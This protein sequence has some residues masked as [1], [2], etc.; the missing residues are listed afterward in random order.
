[1]KPNPIAILCSDLHLSIKPPAC[2]ADTNWLD[3]QGYYLEQLKKLAGHH[4][5]I[6]AGDI[7]D[8]WN[9][10]AELIHFALDNL[11]NDMICIPGQHDLPNHAI[12]EMHRS[13]YG[14]L[15]RAKKIIDLSEE[16]T[17]EEP[18][19]VIYGAGWGQKIPVCK[20]THLKDT[21]NLLVM[22]DFIWIND[23]TKYPGA[24]EDSDIKAHKDKFKQFDAVAIGDNHRGWLRPA[25]GF[26]P[27]TDVINCGTFLRRK[28]DELA[29]CPGVGVLYADGTIE[30]R[31]LDTSIDKFHA[32]AKQREEVAV[33]LEEFIE[34][35]EG[36]GEHG[37]NF[38]E[39]VELHLRTEKIDKRTKEIVLGAL[40]DNKA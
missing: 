16:A 17:H 37:L 18:G 19:L 28:S 31:F 10:N 22:H 12:S 29:Y 27:K 1:M 2:R 33:D 11:P 23:A 6:C 24:G 5:I 3:L 26:L 30:R 35:L 39:A 36:L 21:I 8:K 15:T 13:G 25:G 20:T 38:R 9:S 32:N 7:F 14:V 34:Q 40:D 4:T